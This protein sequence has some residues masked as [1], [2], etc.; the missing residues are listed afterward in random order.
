M[1]PWLVHC[2]I[3]KL[4]MLG[5]LCLANLNSHA[6]Y[7]TGF[8]PTSYTAWTPPSTLMATSWDTL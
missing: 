7:E 1:A 5:H 8:I 4:W 6:D 3:F 2:C